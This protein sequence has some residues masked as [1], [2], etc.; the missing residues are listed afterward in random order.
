MDSS[1][2]AAWGGMILTMAVVVILS[3][4]RA[5]WWCFIPIFFMFMAAFCELAVV[6]IS[7]ISVQ[8]AHTLRFCGMVFGIL[9][10]L[11]IIALYVYWQTVMP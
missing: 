1:K 7:R 6:Y 11:G 5:E 9:T 2:P 10:I 4:F 8:A 3:V